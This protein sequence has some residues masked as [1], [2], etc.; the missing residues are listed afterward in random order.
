MKAL[1][2]LET[3]EYEKLCDQFIHDSLVVIVI[4]DAKQKKM[5]E[6]AVTTLQ[7]AEQLHSQPDALNGSKD[8]KQRHN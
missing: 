6:N 8:G 4:V 1:S 2:F 3:C 7:Q 5:L